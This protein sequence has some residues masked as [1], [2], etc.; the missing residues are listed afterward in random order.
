[1]SVRADILD[2]LATSFRSA[3]TGA[4]YAGRINK[5]ITHDMNLLNETA[6]LVAILDTGRTEVVVRDSTHYRFATELLFRGWLTDSSERGVAQGINEITAD[7][8]LFIDDGAAFH[9]NVLELKFLS[10]EGIRTDSTGSPKKAD[11]VVL[12]RLT[13]VVERGLF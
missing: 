5:V 4:S 13:Y 9:D 11:V 8:L 12:A 1:M 7:I 2:A 3:I 6:P 10:I